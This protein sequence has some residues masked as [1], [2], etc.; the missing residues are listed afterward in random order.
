[1]SCQPASYISYPKISPTGAL[2]S[3]AYTSYMLTYN[4]NLASYIIQQL[5]GNYTYDTINEWNDKWTDTLN[6]VQSQVTELTERI[7]DIQAK[8][9][10]INNAIG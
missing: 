3:G 6:D 4:A 7:S 9:T 2:S 1:M 10:M 5:N 8:L